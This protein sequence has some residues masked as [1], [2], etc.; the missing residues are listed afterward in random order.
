VGTL[1][2]ALHCCHSTVF[3]G[4][5]AA[6][7]LRSAP[8]VLRPWCGHCKKLDPIYKQVG[9]AFKDDSD[10]VIAKM[11][12]KQGQGPPACLWLGASLPLAPYSGN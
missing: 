3:R 11:V 8:G 7:S 4:P 1:S 9:A 5:L 2:C 12:S 6:L 10:V